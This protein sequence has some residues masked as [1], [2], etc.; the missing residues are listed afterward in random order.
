MR[1]SMGTQAHEVNDS[2]VVTIGM[3][4]ISC[5]CFRIPHFKASCN[6][7][8]FIVW[9]QVELSI[10]RTR[11]LKDGGPVWWHFAIEHRVLQS[12]AVG[13]QRTHDSA[14]RICFL[15]LRRRLGKAATTELHQS[16]DWQR[17]MV[18]RLHQ[19]HD[20]RHLRSA[21][22]AKVAQ[23]R[24]SN[25]CSGQCRSG[26]LQETIV[27]ILGCTKSG[28]GSHA[29]QGAHSHITH[30]HTHT[31]HAKLDTAYGLVVASTVLV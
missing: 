23:V 30:T 26:I 17:N 21:S 10:E 19:S 15:G 3:V 5:D 13:G 28:D 20:P 31:H 9:F 16:N 22:G 24:P 2:Q 11:P 18:H 1:Q 6:S 8:L 7:T 12:R 25:H 14:I 29:Q 4:A 27:E